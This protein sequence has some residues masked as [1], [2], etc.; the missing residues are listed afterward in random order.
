MESK[1]KVDL[2]IRGAIIAQA[3]LKMLG[4]RSKVHAKVI[5]ADLID[6]VKTLDAKIKELPAD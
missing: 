1:D 6:H 3:V 4:V 5:L 2:A